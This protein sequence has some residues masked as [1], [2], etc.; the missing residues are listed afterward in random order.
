VGKSEGAAKSR[1][2]PA[3]SAG[4]GNTDE[5]A[6]LKQE[7]DRLD[8]LTDEEAIE[9][10]EGKAPSKRLRNVVKATRAQ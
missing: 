1:A 9:L 7:S 8:F 4:S 10:T 6:R 3:N 2:K 5:E